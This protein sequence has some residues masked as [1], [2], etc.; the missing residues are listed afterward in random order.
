MKTTS[1]RGQ[2]SIDLIIVILVIVV[3]LGGL[4]SVITSISQ[5]QEKIIIREEIDRSATN[6]SNAIIYA[7]SLEGTN[8]EITIN[9]PK[10]NYGKQ[11]G[12]QLLSIT[13]EEVVLTENIT[14][15]NITV[16]EKTAKPSWIETSIMSTQVVIRN[17]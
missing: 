11:T 2:I 10:I 3:V 4:T 6:I 1:L 5:T 17:A 16:I 9:L 14:G 8:F 12:N 13:E 7:K 15:E